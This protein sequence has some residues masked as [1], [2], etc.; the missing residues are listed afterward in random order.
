MKL[1][2][3]T[4][5]YPEKLVKAIDYI[6]DI[7]TAADSIIPLHHLENTAND[8]RLCVNDSKTEFSGFN[9]KCSKKK[10]QVNH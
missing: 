10:N 3:F 7:A 2:S 5:F 1:T 4:F 9:H 8:D 6:D